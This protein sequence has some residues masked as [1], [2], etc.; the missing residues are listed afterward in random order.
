MTSS[1]PQPKTSSPLASI[2]SVVVSL[3]AIGAGRFL[4]WAFGLSFVLPLF[5][6]L[7]TLGVTRRR[8]PPE[9]QVFVGAA[10]AHAA[11]LAWSLIS[12][13][14]FWLDVGFRMGVLGALLWAVSIGGLAWLVAQPGPRPAALLA[15]DNAYSLIQSLLGLPS[16]VRY[17]SSEGLR[18]T[19]VV[20]HLVPLV[21]SSIALGFLARAI[22]ATRRRPVT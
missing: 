22:L 17:L 21:L 12:A 6:A 5:A 10:A 2:L 11:V 7:A 8:F 1:A 9:A 3:A 4:G 15:L 18:V 16:L 20:Q 14:S 19:S 13:V